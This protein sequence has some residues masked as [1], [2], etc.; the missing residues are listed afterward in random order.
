MYFLVCCPICFCKC[1]WSFNWYLQ[2]FCI[3]QPYFFFHIY[4]HLSIPFCYSYLIF[5][6]PM[7]FAW[8][9]TNILH[10]ATIFLLSHLWSFKH[11]LFC[12]HICFHK[13]LW[14]AKWHLQ[15]FYIWQPYLL[16]HLWSVQYSLFC[17][18]IFFINVYEVLGDIHR[19]ISFGSHICSFISIIT[20]IS[21]AWLSYV[22]VSD[23]H[24][25]FNLAIIFL[26]HIYDHFNICPANAYEVW[27]LQIFNILKPFWSFVSMITK[28]FL[29]LYSHLF[30]Q[31]PTKFWVKYFIFGSHIS[32]FISK[33]K[34]D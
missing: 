5:V 26:F 18:H 9:F 33:T 25:Y 11:S 12:Y 16:S 20:S 23:S 17:S 32:S 34:Q 29:V 8:T 27:Q 28:V 31:I 3:L 15:I 10:M 7:K 1:P 24:K 6:L 19:Y 21:L 30:S 22:S 2:I 4:N 13:Y 14:S